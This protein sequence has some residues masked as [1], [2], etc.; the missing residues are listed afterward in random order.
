MMALELQTRAFS[1]H[2][3]PRII[4]QYVNRPWTKRGKT[5]LCSP[6]E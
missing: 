6:S 2:R 4:K 1:T 5:S 3:Y